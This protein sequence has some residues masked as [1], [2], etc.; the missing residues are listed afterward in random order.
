MLS[1]KDSSKSDCS[2]IK[3]RILDLEMEQSL[4]IKYYYSK[5]HLVFEK[6]GN[7]ASY[8]ITDNDRI[9]GPSLAVFDWC[10]LLSTFENFYDCRNPYFNM[11]ASSVSRR[12]E[13]SFET[14]FFG[15]N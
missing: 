14:Q 15:R 5:G 4:P 8:T 9:G 7:A 12:G 3:I 13:K 2:P 10:A 11:L 6:K 1:V